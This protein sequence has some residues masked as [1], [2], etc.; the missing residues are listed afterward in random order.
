MNLAP[1]PLRKISISCKQVYK[2]KTRLNGSV[3]CYKVRLIAR[4]F[5]QEHDIDY[6]ESFAH[7]IKMTIVQSLIVVV[8]RCWPLYQMD[9]NV[10]LHGN[11]AE[12]VYM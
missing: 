10:F 6:D 4:D 12:E 9:V 11:L 8:V 3:E 2:G 5:T 7:I 1:L